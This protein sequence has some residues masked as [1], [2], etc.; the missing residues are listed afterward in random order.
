MELMNKIKKILPVSFDIPEEKIND[1]FQELYEKYPEGEDP[2]GLNLEKAKKTV[3]TFYPLYKDYFKV[4]VFGQENVKDK[5][6]I[7][8]SNHSGQ[9]AFDG[10]L[11]GMAFGLDIYPPRI[12]RGMAERFITNMPFVGTWSAESGTVL[13]DRQ[14]CLQLLE[15]GESVMVF[16]EGV[17]GIA[18][19]TPDYYKLQNFTQGFFRIALSA[20]VEIL[21]VAV[22]GAEET[23]PYIYQ[24]KNIAKKFGL[25]ALPLSP[26]M[27]L[28]PI[29]FLPLPSPVDIY[30][31]KP[32]KPPL[33]LNGEEQDKNIREHI[34]TIENQIKQMIFEGR[35]LRRPFWANKKI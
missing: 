9:V 12:L 26:S 8:V 15:K 23:Y 4:R 24:A 18:K 2:W 28:G 20:Q 3:E 16:P 1:I 21:P 31:G 32:Y 22:V 30:V 14:N 11:L 34:Y 17:N 29:G 33:D 10:L 6:Y 27:L 19:S 5:P 25:P 13:G 35:K 7:V